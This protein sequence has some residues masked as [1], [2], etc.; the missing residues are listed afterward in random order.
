M[1]ISRVTVLGRSKD[2]GNVHDVTFA[3]EDGMVG[4]QAAVRRAIGQSVKVEPGERVKPVTKVEWLLTARRVYYEGGKLYVDSEDTRR[5]SK[6]LAVEVAKATAVVLPRLTR[7]RCRV[8]FQEYPMGDVMVAVTDDTTVDDFKRH[9]LDDHDLI[10]PPGKN[11]LDGCDLDDVSDSTLLC[12]LG[13]LDQV[14]TTTPSTT[15]GQWPWYLHLRS[16]MSIPIFVMTLTNERRGFRVT[17]TEDTVRDLKMMIYAKEG[18]PPDQ[19][20][21][22]YAGKMLVDSSLLCEYGACAHLKQA[23]FHLVLRLRGGMYH[24]SSGRTD[25]TTRRRCKLD[26]FTADGSS[27]SV[28][29]VRRDTLDDVLKKVQAQ[30]P[31]H[32][33]DGAQDDDQRPGESDAAYAGRLKRK[34]SELRRDTKRH[35]V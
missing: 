10:L 15:D 35:R 4:L 20:L 8:D 25:L 16:D 24:E 1:V 21:L 3:I 31:G 29:V 23:T 2:R 28:T 11:T 5:P 33:E 13:V 14:V 9:L 12:D 34:L 26:V 18:I 22:V 17:P 30:L 32:G 6:P 19:Q 27:V 7:V